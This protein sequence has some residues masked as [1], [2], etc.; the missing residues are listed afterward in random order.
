M[1]YDHP[2]QDRK[3]LPSH[4]VFKRNLVTNHSLHTLTFFEP[5]TGNVL[6]TLTPPTGTGTLSSGILTGHVDFLTGT[7]STEG[8]VE[9]VQ[10]EEPEIPTRWVTYEHV[11]VDTILTGMSISV[12]DIEEGGFVMS[13]TDAKNE[14]AT[15]KFGVGWPGN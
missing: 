12:D 3:G 7:L 13:C 11:D 4:I 15:L 14:R 9:G 5:E 1:Q 8:G 6:L 2:S 10:G